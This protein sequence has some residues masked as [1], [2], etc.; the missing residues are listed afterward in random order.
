MV[1]GKPQNDV[2]RAVT[3]IA[4][5]TSLCAC[6]SDGAQ[7]VNA[8][9][10]PQNPASHGTSY[11]IDP[12][13]GQLRLPL[14]QYDL[15]V[16][17]RRV[18]RH[19]QQIL[20]SRCMKGKGRSYPVFDLRHVPLAENRR[21]GIWREDMADRYG[22][23]LPPMTTTEAA[24]LRFNSQTMSADYRRDFDICSRAPEVS[25]LNVEPPSQVAELDRRSYD[26]ALSS[27]EG[28]SALS[29]WRSCM[30]RSGLTKPNGWTDRWSPPEAIASPGS[31]SSKEIAK[32][33][34]ACKKKTRLVEVLA[35]VEAV[36]Q[37]SGVNKMKKPLSHYKKV[38]DEMLGKA[39]ALG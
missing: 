36:Y 21:Y 18:L 3:V 23:A 5:L 38:R 35:Q 1:L 7:H 33:D 28:Q 31:A 26:H 17:D 13:G 6:S 14:D 2:R 15:T 39:R 29:A 11:S 32:V 4:L 10:E 30:Q 19:G 37:T 16:S 9:T 22:Y 20:V 25:T 12:A 34:V 27:R 24:E 8:E